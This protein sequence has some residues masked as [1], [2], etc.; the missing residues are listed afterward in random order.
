MV[1]ALVLVVH[2]LVVWGQSD[3]LATLF[4]DTSRFVTTMF[5]GVF[6]A[7]MALGAILAWHSQTNRSWARWMFMFFCF[8]YAIDCLLGTLTIGPLH[9]GMSRPYGVFRGPISFSIW[10]YLVWLA[11]SK[12][13]YLRR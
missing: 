6:G 10:G 8:A 7:L 5:W 1:W 3:W 4:S 11:W 9:E 12:R 13:P 2:A